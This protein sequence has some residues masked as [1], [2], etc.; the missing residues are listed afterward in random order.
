MAQ[1]DVRRA[2]QREGGDHG[3]GAASKRHAGQMKLGAVGVSHFHQQISQNSGTPF[4]LP[5]SVFL[6]RL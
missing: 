2:E 4:L 6:R 1:C 5:K 3:G